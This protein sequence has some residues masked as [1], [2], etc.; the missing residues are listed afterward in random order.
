MIQFIKFW[1]GKKIT[2]DNTHKSDFVGLAIDEE[3]S[4]RHSS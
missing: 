3:R 4:A 2:L 1:G